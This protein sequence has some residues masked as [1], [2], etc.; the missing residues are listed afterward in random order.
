MFNVR[1]INDAIGNGLFAT[2]DIKKKC[3]L[4][5]VPPIDK[6]I[7]GNHCNGMIVLGTMCDTLFELVLPRYRE[8]VMQVKFDGRPQPHHFFANT[9]TC[10]GEHVPRNHCP[11]NWQDV[12]KAE[13]IFPLLTKT[14]NQYGPVVSCNCD[15]FPHH[16]LHVKNIFA[17]FQMH[18][19]PFQPNGEIN[20]QHATS[21]NHRD[22]LGVENAAIRYNGKDG[23]VY[24][25]VEKGVKANDQILINYSKTF[26][27]EV[28]HEQ[29]CWSALENLEH[30]EAN[31]ERWKMGI[32]ITWWLHQTTLPFSRPK[33]EKAFDCLLQKNF[34][35]DAFTHRFLTKLATI[36]PSK[37]EQIKALLTQSIPRPRKQQK[38][39][40]LLNPEILNLKQGDIV[41]VYEPSYWGLQS[42]NPLW[43]TYLIGSVWGGERKR[44][45]T[46]TCIDSKFP[47]WFGKENILLHGVHNKQTRRLGKLI[48]VNQAELEGTSA[49]GGANFYYRWDIYELAENE[50]PFPTT[51]K[52]TQI[53]KIH[54]RIRGLKEKDRLPTV[55][56]LV[57]WNHLKWRTES[58]QKQRDIMKLKL[59]QLFPHLPLTIVET[60][61]ATIYDEAYSLDHYCSTSHVNVP[62][63][64]QG[65]EAT[66]FFETSET[67]VF[68]IN[69]FYV[70]SNGE[71]YWGEYLHR[72][73]HGFG[74]V[75]FPNGTSYIGMFHDNR[76]HGQGTMYRGNGDEFV[77]IFSN[78]QLLQGTV[79]YASGNVYKGALKAW[80]RHGMGQLTTTNY[81]YQGNWQDDILHTDAR[82]QKEIDRLKAEKKRDNIEI[83]TLKKDIARLQA[84]K[85]PCPVPDPLGNK[86]AKKN[87][88]IL[89]IVHQ[90]TK[91]LVAPV[92][93]SWDQPVHKVFAFMAEREKIEQAA[94]N[95]IWHQNLVKP[96]DSPKSL[97]MKE[98]QTACVYFYKGISL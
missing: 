68:S 35:S 89:R 58:D 49:D 41:C 31:R 84:K 42:S 32:A 81:V 17:E 78:N 27:Q 43:C 46:A 95:L 3:N 98:G 36:Y 62:S 13:T 56:E 72:K 14:W 91:K 77:G 33:L 25:Q 19:V 71:K 8:Y 7:N 64:L 93:I 86:K 20:K 67:I 48:K 92:K 96:T 55:E 38:Q 34:V 5:Y 11:S 90:C 45:I 79:R 52:D 66:Q 15:K 73:R 54:A 70:E 28:N 37:A 51:V 87:K 83:A 74:K 18:Y 26:F 24:I 63:S 1:Y 60:M 97:G 80:K 94:C 12:Y 76:Y 23:S 82:L 75:L 61:E 21:V 30:N 6:I 44:H 10:R 69:A 57:E 9:T 50:T 53:Q 88:V 29:L 59:K 16:T 47:E 65:K 85:R 2:T 39:A 40:P 4:I 22:N